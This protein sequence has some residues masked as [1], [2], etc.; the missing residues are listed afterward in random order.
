MRRM[1][2]S[3]WTTFFVAL[4]AGAAAWAAWRFLPRDRR[5]LA[6]AAPGRPRA[7]EGAGS[8]P[9]RVEEPSRAPRPTSSP[10]AA[11]ESGEAAE[12]ARCAAVTQGGT[13]CSREAEPGSATCWQHA[14]S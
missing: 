3:R 1:S 10:G 8:A 6:S 14:A 12:P 9:A 7:G 5:R 13:R 2:R 4:L 11:A